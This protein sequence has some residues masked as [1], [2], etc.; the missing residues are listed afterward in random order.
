MSAIDLED[1]RR[2]AADQAVRQGI[3]SVHEMGGP[4]AMGAADFDAWRFGRWPVEVIPYWGGLD[5]RFV[6]ERDLRQIGGDL[7]LDGSMGSHTAALSE[8]Y[9]DLPSTSGHLEY[10]DVT[11]IELFTEATHAGI[12]V[13]VHAIGDAAIDQAVRCWQRG[14]GATSRTTSKGA[15]A[16]CAI[17]WSTPR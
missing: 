4:D 15:C 11:L 9:A 12:Q 8:P 17:A 14:G 2:A 1:A 7:W 10:D 3:G 6:V 13:A 5:L 16:A